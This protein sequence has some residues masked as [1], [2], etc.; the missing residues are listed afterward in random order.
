MRLLI[1]KP[2]NRFLDKEAN[3][4]NVQMTNINVIMSEGYSNKEKKISEISIMLPSTK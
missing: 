2:S 3:L 4:P 1:R